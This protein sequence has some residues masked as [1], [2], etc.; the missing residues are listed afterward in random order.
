MQYGCG[1]C[2][3]NPRIPVYD[4]FFR[5]KHFRETAVRGTCNSSKVIFEQLTFEQLISSNSS[6]SNCIR[7]I[8]LD[9]RR[10]HMYLYASVPDFILQNNL[11]AK[12]M[13]FNLPVNNLSYRIDFWLFV[14]NR[15]LKINLLADG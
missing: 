12:I 6:S 15:L 9:S 11:A 1:L 8:Y 14:D 10:C 2:N 7:A 5:A 4:N 3:N 13:L